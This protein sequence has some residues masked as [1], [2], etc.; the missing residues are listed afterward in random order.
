MIAIVDLLGWRLFRRRQLV[1]QRLTAAPTARVQ[2]EAGKLRAAISHPPVRRYSIMA[3][4]D[5]Y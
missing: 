4:N 5:R 1:G 2:A 3:V